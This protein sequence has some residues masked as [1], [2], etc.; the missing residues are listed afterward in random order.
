MIRAKGSKQT[1]S[2]FRAEK[3]ALLIAV[4][5]GFKVGATA[6][7]LSVSPANYAQ[8]SFG[9]SVELSGLDGSNGF[10]IR[11]IGFEDNSGRS[12]SS[13]GD[14][15]N[16][17]VDDL[18]IGT[19]TNSTFFIAGESYVLF[20]GGSVGGGGLIEL[21]EQN[22]SNALDGSDGFL[23]NGINGRTSVSSAGDVNADGVADLIIGAHL[24]DP[25]GND[26]AGET[27]VLFGSGSVGSAGTI[28]VSALD[29]SN[30]F[31]IN[32]I[33]A[34][35][36]SG[37]SVSSAGD[38]NGDG[39]TDLIIG[40]NSA[41]PNGNNSAGE[42]Y[43]VFGGSGVGGVGTFELSDLD[44]SNG[45]VING[46]NA[47][48]ETGR[49]VSN[50][51]DVNADGVDDLIIGA[52]GASYVVF[53]GSGVGSSGTIELSGLDGSDGFVINGINANDFAGT[54]VS[55]A[56]DINGDGVDDLIIGA[57]HADPD[58]TSRA[59]E[60]YVVFGG[61]GVGSSSS[62]EL[63]GLDGSDGF[64]INGI[65]ATDFS[66]TSVS[67]AGD[68]NGDGVDDLIIGAS[69]AGPSLV[70]ESYVVFGR[71]FAPQFCNG[72]TVTVDLNL[73]QTPGPGNDVILGT[74]GKDII[75]GSAGN[76]TIC[77][78]SGNDTIHGGTGDDWIDGGNGA[79]DL[80]GGQ[81]DDVI[82]G[83]SGDDE[84]NGGAGADIIFGDGGIDTMFGGSGDDVITGGSGDDVIRGNADADIIH[85]GSGVDMVNGGSGDDE[86]NGGADDDM[87]LGGTGDDEVNGGA[88][89]DAVG[90][91]P[92][93]DVLNG[94]TGADLC[95]G[96][97][98]TSDTASNCE[99]VKMI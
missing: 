73:G 72:L 71:A 91:G 68:I 46:I 3:R 11:G 28:P 88:G 61:S 62:I 33:D 96:G 22:G 36:G 80:R 54:S 95:D 87:V 19:D 94:G 18:I 43:V 89:D 83:G 8:G 31:V 99:T 45:F 86:V 67:S 69:G 40:A 37:I 25:N 57:S 63:S 16:D 5:A 81:G 23:I 98:G 49:S 47:D 76:D 50:A 55:S 56:G 79:D 85:G 44:G 82:A 10:V 17:G 42:S 51:G 53:G 48:D 29:G 59:G 24:A 65:D 41:D 58:G 64:A 14:V 15:N 27:Y 12:V 78:M 38:V 75:R 20:G 32:G 92:G 30:G 97:R 77:G 39:A 34:F 21:L 35:D 2:D 90:G 7:M 93:D 60:S 66:G 1:C 74:T 84:L 26:R 4:N 52:A 6:L 70:G 9:A 13:A